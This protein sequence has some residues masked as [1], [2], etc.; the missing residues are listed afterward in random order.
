[1]SRDVILPEMLPVA[2]VWLLYGSC[3]VLVWPQMRVPAP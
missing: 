1:M 3:M 2:G